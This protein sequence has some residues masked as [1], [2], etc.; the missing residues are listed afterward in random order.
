ML[1][2]ENILGFDISGRGGTFGGTPPATEF[3]VPPGPP[4]SAGP[5]KPTNLLVLLLPVEGSI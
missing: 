4:L 5:L 2:L 1:L 3:G